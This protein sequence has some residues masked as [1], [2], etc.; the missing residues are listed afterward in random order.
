MGEADPNKYTDQQNTSG[1][2]EALMNTDKEL[3]CKATGPRAYFRKDDQDGFSEK[4]TSQLRP[5]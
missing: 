3:G 4:V 5:K 2:D 1:F